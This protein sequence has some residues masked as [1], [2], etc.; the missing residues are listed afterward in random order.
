[1]ARLLV[2]TDYFIIN[3][4]SRMLI[5]KE[6]KPMRDEWN[7]TTQVPLK[8]HVGIS[9][10]VQPSVIKLSATKHVYEL[11]HLFGLTDCNPAKMPYDAKEDLRNRKKQEDKLSSNDVQVYRRGMCIARFL[12]DTVLYRIK[13]LL[14]NSDELSILQ[15]GATWTH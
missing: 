4:K 14:V 9:V 7:I 5:D 3:S 10:D 6:L 8:Q 12:E 13:T 2:D 15:R 1:M 11:V